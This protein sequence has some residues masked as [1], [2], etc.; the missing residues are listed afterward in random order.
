M[1]ARR[2]QMCCSSPLAGAEPSGCAESGTPP[3]SYVQQPSPPRCP[4]AR[5]PTVPVVSGCGSKRGRLW[6]SA[7]G[8]GCIRLRS[9]MMCACAGAQS[10][11][12]GVLDR[13][14]PHRG[15][16]TPA[17]FHASRPPLRPLSLALLPHAH[18]GAVPLPDTDSLCSHNLMTSCYWAGRWISC[19]FKTRNG[20]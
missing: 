1:S 15:L 5:C 11:S 9:L 6:V 8:R 7:A 13:A 10:L 18:P 20:E 14:N 4:R 19:A 2:G 17:T 16:S 3:Y 12:A